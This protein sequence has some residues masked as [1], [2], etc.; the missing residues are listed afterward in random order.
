M[1]ISHPLAHIEVVES[2]DAFEAATEDMMEVIA[3]TVGTEKIPM[4]IWLDADAKRVH[5]RNGIVVMRVR[6]FEQLYG[7]I[8]A[9]SSADDIASAP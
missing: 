4:L 3:H 9:P 7:R 6:D 1:T 5:I 2:A 8:D